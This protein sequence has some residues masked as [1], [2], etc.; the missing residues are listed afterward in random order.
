MSSRACTC[1]FL[2]WLKL[3]YLFA[4]S[5]VFQFFVSLQNNAVLFRCLF[6]LSP[7]CG[8]DICD[9]RIHVRCFVC[10]HRISAVAG[11]V[12]RFSGGFTENL[13]QEDEVRENR[14]VFIGRNLEKEALLQEV[15]APLGRKHYSNRRRG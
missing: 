13:W 5:H 14:F 4:I 11:A 9:F 3:N 8:S 2:V 1:C 6:L 7:S 10:F 12:P 15:K